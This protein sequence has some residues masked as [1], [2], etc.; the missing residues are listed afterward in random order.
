[1][2]ETWFALFL[3]INVPRIR[4]T[5]SW[6]GFRSTKEVDEKW[7]NGKYLIWESFEIFRNKVGKYFDWNTYVSI[8]K[9]F[10]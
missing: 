6:W 4:P 5:A 7:V 2:H 9:I 10:D 3:N 1:M 8:Q